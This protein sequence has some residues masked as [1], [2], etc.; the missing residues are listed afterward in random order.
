MPPMSHPR[1]I[2]LETLNQRGPLTL[3]E[4]ARAAQRSPLATRYHVDL[5]VAEGLLRVDGVA[6]R[7]GV[8]RP[9]A[10]YAL[11]ENAHAQLPKQYAWFAAQL[12]EEFTR[13]RGEKETRA[14]LRRLGRRLAESTLPRRAT[15]LE[16]RVARA[17][18]FLRTRGYAAQWEKSNDGLVLRVRHCPYRQVAQ[19]WRAACEM[20]LA[21]IGE[22][23]HATLDLTH[24]IARQDAHCVFILKP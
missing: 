14:L 4:L 16:T 15:R 1:Q 7:D 20:D 19:T 24:C 10:L 11:A 9:Q 23:T 6:R 5:L 3:A 13:A 2:I 18:T 8:G 17:V 12:L 22:L 21:L